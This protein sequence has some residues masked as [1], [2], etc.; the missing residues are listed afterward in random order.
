MAKYQ[1]VVVITMVTWVGI[2]KERTCMHSIFVE[3]E[4]VSKMVELP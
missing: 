3:E 2:T 1:T 4:N